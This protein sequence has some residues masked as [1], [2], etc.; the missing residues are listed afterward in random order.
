MS[1]GRRRHADMTTRRYAE[2]NLFLCH[3]CAFLIE[4]A[5]VFYG[6]VPIRRN[7]T[8]YRP[9]GSARRISE[10]VSCKI[11]TW[12][13]SATMHT[14]VLRRKA[15]VNTPLSFVV[16]SL[17]SFSA[18]LLLIMCIDAQCNRHHTLRL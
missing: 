18:K 2:I 14:S 5:L 9:F 16:N 1:N 12:Q 3:A 10:S 13:K 8:A 7:L 17:T 6:N 15:D 11:S 4:V